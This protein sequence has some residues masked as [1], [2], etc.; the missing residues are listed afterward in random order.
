MSHLMSEDFNI[1]RALTPTNE[2]L[3]RRRILDKPSETPGVNIENKKTVHIRQEIRLSKNQDVRTFNPFVTE[4]NKDVWTSSC[5]GHDE[6]KIRDQR[7][8]LS[9]SDLLRFCHH[10]VYELISKEKINR[11]CPLDETSSCYTNKAASQTD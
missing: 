2:S 11:K 8:K 1:H 4:F 10:Q 7:L 3:G 6:E 9:M 5:S